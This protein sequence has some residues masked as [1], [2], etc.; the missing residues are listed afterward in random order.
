MKFEE[1]CLEEGG[2]IFHYACISDKGCVRKTNEDDFLVAVDHGIFAIA[3]G[4]G[5]LTGGEIASK[6]ALTSL[7]NSMDGY[8]QQLLVKFFRTREYMFQEKL[9]KAIEEANLQVYNSGNNQKRKFATTLV[10]L[11]LSNDFCTIGHVGDSRVYLLRDNLFSQLTTDHTVAQELSVKT[12]ISSDSQYHNVITRAIG[13]NT[14]VV[15]DILSRKIRKNDTLLLCSDGLSSMVSEQIIEN[16]LSEPEPVRVSV[17]KLIQAAK[18]AGG[19]DNVT[20]I[21]IKCTG[22]E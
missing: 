5:G 16:I 7:K 12:T 8:R 3:D 20:V 15:P 14:T 13:A 4:V 1:G 17:R 9:T 19:K 6:L 18:D 2:L 22:K 21:L 10:A 11:G